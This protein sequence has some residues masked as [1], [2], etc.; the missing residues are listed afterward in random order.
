MGC[1]PEAT[2]RNSVDGIKKSNLKMVTGSFFVIVLFPGVGVV[3]MVGRRNETNTLQRA[4]PP[5]LLH[6]IMISRI[7][8]RSDRVRAQSYN[9]TVIL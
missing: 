5:A 3:V 8:V 4:T 7:G 6:Q 2:L 1:V 9:E